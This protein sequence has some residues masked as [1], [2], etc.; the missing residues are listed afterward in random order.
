MNHFLQINL[1][2][3]GLWWTRLADERRRVVTLQELPPPLRKRVSRLFHKWV[4][5]EFKEIVYNTRN[6]KPFLVNQKR[7]TAK[8]LHMRKNQIESLEL[9]A[10]WIDYIRRREVALRRIMGHYSKAS[11]ICPDCDIKVEAKRV[12]CTDHNCDSWNKIYKC[13][14]DP[15]FHPKVPLSST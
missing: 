15:V 11:W 9:I 5:N 4:T 3:Y 2:G 6:E 8:E 12:A 14:K 13:T 10:W 1:D 7:R